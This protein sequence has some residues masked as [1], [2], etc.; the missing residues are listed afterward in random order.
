[1]T[2]SI[3]ASSLRC[4][5][6][7]D[8]DECIRSLK[9][10]QINS[11]VLNLDDMEEPVV[12][13]YF[14]MVNPG[15]LA[16]HDLMYSAT[17]TVMADLIKK[18][19]FSREELAR[20]GVFW[21][22]SSFTV[23]DSEKRYFSETRSEDSYA[24]PMPIVGYNKLPEKLAREHGLS[25][26][27]HSYATACT[28]SAN[29]LIYADMFMARGDIDHAII[30][31]SE[32]YNAATVLGFFGL[33]L[34]SG[35]RKILPFDA[36]RDGL[37]LGEGCAAVLVS[38]TKSSTARFLGGACNT[39]SFS[40]TAAN[41]DGSTIAHVVEKALATAD[42]KPEEISAIKVHG[43]ASLLN[44]EAEAAGLLSVFGQQSLPPV[45]ALKPYIGHTLGACG[46]VEL[47]LVDGAL[48]AGFIPSNPNVAT[49]ASVL[50]LGLNQ[51]V[52][53]QQ[54]GRFLLNYFAFGGN[55]TSLVLEYDLDAGE[56]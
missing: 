25:S 4:A 37:I 47:A 50:G 40:L 18:S 53:D 20:T 27:V 29:A 14:P 52:I 51:S 49:D 1:M 21:G 38:K 24:L 12:A 19:G 55:N 5:L 26:C 34:L 16:A 11:K 28:S 31:G 3:L 43:T 42:K 48:R 46:A 56:H 8:I 7:S 9:A 32:F 15:G 36:D 30:V 33:E 23:S 41:T 10:A 22:S 45:F 39:D 2:C 35:K 44:D 6:G 17:E 13:P 54:H